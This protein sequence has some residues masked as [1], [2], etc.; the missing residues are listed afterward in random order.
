MASRLNR[1]RD[2]RFLYWRLP[3]L[4][5]SLALATTA[6][7]GALAQRGAPD[8]LAPASDSVLA[9]FLN[10]IERNAHLR[11]PFIAAELRSITASAD[12]QAVW[13]VGHTGT[14]LKSSDG[15][16][17][18]EARTSGTAA[19]LVSVTFADDGRTGRAVGEGGTILK[20]SDGGDTWEA[21]TSGT[22]AP[23]VS[24]TFVADGRTGWAV[25]DGGTILKSSDGGD[26]WEARTSGTTD[27]LLSVTFADDGRTGWA[28]GQGGTILKSSDAGDTWE[29]R[30][31]GTTNRLYSVTF[32]DDG[33]TGWAV[34]D[35]GTI[36]KSSDAGDNWESRYTGNSLNAVTFAADGRTGWAVG[37]RGTILK[38]IDAG[39]NWES[40]YSGTGNSLNA[41]TF[42]ADGLTGWAVGDSGAILKSTDA[43]DTWEPPYVGGSFNSVTFAADGLTGWAVG[44]R[45][46]I[47]KSID[48][49]D[50]WEPRYSGTTEWLFSVTFADEGRTGWAVGSDGTILKSI[51]GGDTW[52]ARSSGTAYEFTSAT[53][54]NDGLTGWAVANTLAVY[55]STDGGV[56]WEGAFPGSSLDFMLSSV[57]FAND[58]LT[59]WAGGVEIID[60]GFLPDFRSVILKSIDGGGT[61]ETRYSGTNRGT[62]E[63][64]SSVMFAA[65]GRTGWAVGRAG[66]ILKSI[67]GGDTW[68][69]RYSGTTEWLT[70]VTFADDGRTGWAVGSGGTILKSIDGGDNWEARSSGT[71]YGLTSVAFANDGAEPAQQAIDGGRTGWAVGAGGTILKSTDSGDNWRRL[72]A[73]DDYRKY[74]A[75][76][77]WVLFALAIPTLVPVFRHPPPA[78]RAPGIADH[79]ISDRPITAG[80]PDPLQ[81][82][83]IADA[84]SR[85]LRNENTEPPL[86]IAITGDWGD[87]KSS[88]M[89]LLQADLEKHGTKTVW[90]NAWHHQKEKHL[91]AALLQ[92]VRDQAI[93]S[94]WR[95]RKWEFLRALEFRRRLVWS[96]AR[97]HPG[98][99][100]LTLALIGSL[101]LG[102]LWED[103]PRPIE[104]IATESNW[105]PKLID[106]LLENN[107]FPDKFLEFLPPSA[108]AAIAFFNAFAAPIKRSGA[109]PGRLMAV[110]SG[111][112]RVKRFGNQL[113]FRYR[114]GRAFREVTDALRPNTLL[115]LIDDLDRC[116][117]EQ[118]VEILEAMNF[119]VSAGRCYIVIGIA[120][121]QVEHCVGL[122]FKEI[123]AETIEIPDGG[124]GSEVRPRKKRRDYAR[125]YLEKLINMEI[126]IPKLTDAGAARL[127]EAV[128]AERDELRRVLIH[129][130]TRLAACVVVLA[131]PVAGY[132]GYGMFQAA[133]DSTVFESTAPERFSSTGTTEPIGPTPDPIVTPDPSSGPGAA[134]AEALSGFVPGA[135]DAVPWWFSLLPAGSLLFATVVAITLLLMRRQEDRIQDSPAFTR[136]LKI[137]HPLIRAKTNSPRQMK[138][139]MNRVRYFAMASSV[140]TPCRN[141]PELRLSGPPNEQHFS[142]SMLVALATLDDLGE[143]LVIASLRRT[144]EEAPVADIDGIGEALRKHRGKFENENIDEEDFA[145]FLRR[146][147][148]VVVH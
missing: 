130:A 91:F 28:V 126:A 67:D 104:L 36:L 7:I 92:A 125:N 1:L 37:E 132:F 50:N 69:A 8:P 140:S 71:A 112:F 90:F 146:A 24:V 63:W 147:S 139:F 26:T 95:L 35:G 34:G 84:L 13:A 87:G 119:L 101:F 143:D 136:A 18:W 44:E 111:G 56:T 2:R 55:K 17:T 62:P 32:A 12:G 45:G 68:E 49:G 38:S 51:D 75:P 39:D 27:R 128:S 82:R 70:S 60:D 145:R 54:A 21:R 120:P 123:A 3:W 103:P 40:R 118:V 22:A 42:A 43:G 115:V 113:G 72:N 138:R 66:I 10:P 102:V 80:D 46:I 4:V 144:N 142:E 133:P 135:K 5:I 148:G 47:L 129:F 79:F 107:P 77:T 9:R 53:F 96:R 33:R 78:E 86:T 109:N 124:D 100:A 108:A 64:L 73:K 57:T 127:A 81:R 97:R 14:I 110:A 141:H 15:G 121:K 114:F 74:P 93:P 52:D 65:N 6:L 88:L 105:L 61:W 59:G 23:L 76:W 99:T 29:A 98:W 89:N 25:G 58:R 48:A 11:L 85:F 94:I 41:V 31:S 122:G 20:S 116:Q 16:D 117:P 137:W 106:A 83:S 134:T 19:P 30:T 131:I